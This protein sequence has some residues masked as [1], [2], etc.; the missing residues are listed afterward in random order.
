M[1]FTGTV[2]SRLAPRNLIV[3]TRPSLLCLRLQ[4]SHRSQAPCPDTSHNAKSA[5]PPAPQANDD[6]IDNLPFQNVLSLLYC[7]HL[8]VPSSGVR[9]QAV[10]QHSRGVRL[11][12]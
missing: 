1:V 12:I 10:L 3:T 5:P 8:P 6:L 11:Q 2:S 4:F 9:S 7:L